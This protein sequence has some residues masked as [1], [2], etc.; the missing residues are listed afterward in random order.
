MHSI[1]SKS[2]LEGVYIQVQQ[3]STVVKLADYNAKT[4]FHLAQYTHGFFIN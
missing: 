2:D 4:G 3:K 1:G